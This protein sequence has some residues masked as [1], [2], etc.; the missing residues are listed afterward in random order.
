MIP[1]MSS[2]TSNAAT[3]RDTLRR[4]RRLA[5]LLDNAYTIPGTRIRIG[6]DAIIGLVPGLGDVVTALLALYI[7]IKANQF[8][9]RRR[10]LALMLINVAI[11]LFGGA[12][13]IL[14]DI[15]DI[16]WKCNARNLRLLEKE[17]ARSKR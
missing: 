12:I 14:G 9:V 5:T 11:D 2:A 10:T 1:A 3:H 17:M 16:A 4:L 8:G 6:L 13:P 15:F 7:V